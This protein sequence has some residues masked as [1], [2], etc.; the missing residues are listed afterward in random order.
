MRGK[1]VVE[2][3]I[4]MMLSTY[5]SRYVASLPRALVDEQG[6]VGAGCGETH[7]AKVVPKALEPSMWRLFEAV[8]R[9]DEQA[10]VIVTEGVVESCRLMIVHTFGKIAVQEHVLDSPA[11]GE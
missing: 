6:A 10:Y 3:A 1:S 9:F 2:D 4:R 7:A 5:T 8:D 11:I